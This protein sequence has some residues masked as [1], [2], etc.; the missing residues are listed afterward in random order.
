MHL[1]ESHV[2]QCDSSLTMTPIPIQIEAGCHMT[3]TVIGE[4]PGFSAK[5]AGVIFGILPAL[6]F[7]DGLISREQVWIDRGAIATQLTT[8][9][10]APGPRHAEEPGQVRIARLNSRR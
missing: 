5:T 6:A 9:G 7:R 10:S 1:F 2:L 8:P 4:M 3:G